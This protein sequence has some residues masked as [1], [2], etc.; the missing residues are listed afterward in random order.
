MITGGQRPLDKPAKI[1]LLLRLLF[2]RPREFLERIAVLI[3]DRREARLFENGRGPEYAERTSLPEAISRLSEI[4][5]V[6]FEKLFSERE[7]QSIHDWVARKSRELQSDPASPFPVFWSADTSLMRL[8]YALV[9]VLK[10]KSVFET[11]VAY[12]VTTETVLTALHG[13][14]S[15]KLYSVDLPPLRNKAGDSGIGVM[16]RPEHRDRWHF[17]RGSS[18]VLLPALLER[19]LGPVGLFIHDSANV[20]SMQSFELNLLWEHLTDNG[21]V[22]VNNIG[23]NMA[24]E[25]FVREKGGCRWFVIEQVDKP[26]DLTGLLLR[27]GAGRS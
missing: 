8:A 27:T 21:A 17:S 7:F 24:F 26:G 23:R 16:V 5:D 4:F 20:Y 19:G 6:D 3:E 2:T 25:E 14:G 15:G 18:K 10:P 11:G 12:G 1:L 9:K 13:N 22:L